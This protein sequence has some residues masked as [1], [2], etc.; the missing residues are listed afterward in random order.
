MNP[1][2]ALGKLNR[3]VVSSSSSSAANKTEKSLI[4]LSKLRVS[5]W[6]V[7]KRLLLSNVIPNSVSNSCFGNSEDIFCDIISAPN[8]PTLNTEVGFSPS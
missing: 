8:P 5:G 2:S 6:Y 7:T 1:V 4:E 3:I